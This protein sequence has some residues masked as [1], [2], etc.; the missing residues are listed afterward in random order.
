MDDHRTVKDMLYEHWARVGKAVASSKRLELLDLLA[1][2]E[3][4]VELLAGEADLSVTNASAHLAALHAARLVDRRKAAQFVYYRLADPELVGLLRLLERIGR[5]RFHDV[6]EVARTYLED[7]DALEP[8]EAA[9]L[10][11]RLR[12]GEVTV[13]DV[14]PAHEYAAGHI[15]GAVSVPPGTLQRRLADIPRSREIVAYCRGPYC[16][17]AVEAV[18]ALRRR[19]YRARRLRNGF[20]DWR[21]AGYPVAADPETTRAPA[22]RRP[23]RRP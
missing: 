13:L 8:V 12:E 11:R 20:P 23:R 3:K 2:G 10:R 1:Q 5:R 4:S 16:V 18:E 6:E 14:R 17:Y 19:G 21:G 7:R 22:V 9:E 15:P